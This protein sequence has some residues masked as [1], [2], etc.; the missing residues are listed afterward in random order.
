MSS[1][2]KYNSVCLALASYNSD[3]ID[4]NAVDSHQDDPC[5]TAPS[6]SSII[7]LLIFV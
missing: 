6:E 2:W 4:D 3:I 1:C 7:L 5:E